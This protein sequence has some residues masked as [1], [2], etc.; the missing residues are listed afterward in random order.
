MLMDKYAANLTFFKRFIDDVIA[1]WKSTGT[2]E[3]KEA[4]TNF[5]ADLNN[6]DLELRWIV[7]K[8]TMSVDFMDL[9]LSLIHI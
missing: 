5:V 8:P 7:E 4:W 6:P 1:A 3:D 2:Q 9:T